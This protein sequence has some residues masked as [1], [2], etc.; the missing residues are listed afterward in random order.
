MSDREERGERGERVGD[1]AR[2]PGKFGLLLRLFAFAADGIVKKG[3]ETNLYKVIIIHMKEDQ[4]LGT[5]TLTH[6]RTQ[7]RIYTT[8]LFAKNGCTSFK[9]RTFRD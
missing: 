9:S 3:G 2:E 1:R 8:T 4:I 5:H 6:T 7:R